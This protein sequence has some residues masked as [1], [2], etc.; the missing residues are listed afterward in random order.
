MYDST[1]AFTSK[2]TADVIVPPEPFATCTSELK[3]KKETP[4][5]RDA[6]ATLFPC[7]YSVALRRSWG[8]VD[9]SDMVTRKTVWVPRRAE[10]ME[11]GELRSAF[12]SSTGPPRD[13]RDRAEGEVGSRATARMEKWA[14][15]WGE[16]RTCRIR[17]EPWFPVAPKTVRMFLGMVGLGWGRWKGGRGGL[18]GLCMVVEM[19]RLFWKTEVWGGP[20]FFVNEMDDVD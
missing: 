2:P 9:Q 6:S 10:A 7:K 20:S 19:G 12:T 13:W 18:G 4:A 11:G 16:D 5:A 8:G 17:E 3:I 14:E 15:R 1:S